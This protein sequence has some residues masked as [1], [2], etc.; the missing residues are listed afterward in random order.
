MNYLFGSEQ[1]AIQ[2]KTLLKTIYNCIGEYRYPLKLRNFY[3]RKTLPDNFEPKDIWDAGCGRGQTTFFL[4]HQYPKANII[5][6]DINTQI[7]EDCKIILCKSEKFNNVS[8]HIYD[9]LE[10]TFENMFDMIICFEVLEHI[11]DYEAALQKLSLALRPNGYLIIHT[12]A[13]DRFQKDN[14][15]LRKIR[16]PAKKITPLEKGQ[17]HVREGFTKVEL[18]NCLI[19]NGLDPKLKWTFGPLAMYAH[20]IYEMT[21]SRSSFMVATFPFLI[22]LG[23]IDWYLPKKEGG[24]ILILAQKK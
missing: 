9:L 13:A 7:I 3:L 20:T 11:D 12:P 4:S 19:K 24:G 5:G 17:Y 2:N 1:A 22:S 18:S 15:G 16:E 23:L 6:T 8:F 10:S 21:R 14:F